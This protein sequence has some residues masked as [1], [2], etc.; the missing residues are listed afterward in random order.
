M[1]HSNISVWLLLLATAIF[2]STEVSA[3]GRRSVPTINADRARE[4]AREQV[5]WRERACP[6]STLARDFLKSIY[7]QTNYKGLSAVQVV[8]GWRLRPDAWKDEPMILIHDAQLRQQLGI[9]GNYARFSELFD[10]TLGYR[11][12]SL[13]A[14]LPERMRQ[15]VRKSQAAIELDEKVGMIILLTEGQLVQPLP[16]SIAALPAWRLEAEILYNNT[17]VWAII[18]IL[19]AAAGILLLISTRIK[20]TL[21]TK[22]QNN[23]TTKGKLK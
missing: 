11:I 6:L 12:N 15:I 5:Y 3:E 17:P 14:E 10:D 9:E 18:L 23:K 19:L 13:G 8:Y 22:Q 1:R 7:G 20:Y 4:A 16:D 21:T 2:V